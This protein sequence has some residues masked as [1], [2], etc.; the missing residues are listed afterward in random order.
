MS[1]ILLHPPGTS[2]RFT[3][4]FSSMHLK[5]NTQ[6]KILKWWVTLRSG[7]YLSLFIRLLTIPLNKHH[8]ISKIENYQRDISL[9]QTNNNVSINSTNIKCQT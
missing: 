3:K 1:W 7:I 8:Q 5:G 4:T 6:L 9:F 2:L